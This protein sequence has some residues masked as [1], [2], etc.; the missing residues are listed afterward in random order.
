M[1]KRV[2]SANAVDQRYNRRS[3]VPVYMSYRKAKGNT[4]DGNKAVNHHGNEN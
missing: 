1:A 4:W 2:G 3:D